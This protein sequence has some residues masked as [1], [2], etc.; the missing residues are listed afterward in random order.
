[1]DKNLGQ[2]LFY[3][4]KRL[5]GILREAEKVLVAFSGGVDST[6]LLFKAIEVLGPEK[7]LAVTAFSA[8]IPKEELD[9]AK[10][11]ANHFKAPHM[12][13]E[14]DELRRQE[15]VSNTLQRCYYCKKELYGKLIDLRQENNLSEVMDGSNSE[16]END[17]RPGMIA[18]HELGV[19]S[20]LQEAKLFK[21]EIRQLS[22][23][24][25]LPTWN[26][27]SAAC[28]ASRF[29]YGEKLEAHK[30]ERVELAEKSLRE[31]GFVQDMRVR[32]H[33]DLARI[34]IAE[35]E[36]ELLIEKRREIL[37]QLKEAG[38]TYTTLDLGG[39]VSGS[40]NRLVL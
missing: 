34:E 3:K 8:L 13:L 21:G 7:V 5:E 17:Y 15:I 27:P 33:G 40:M 1:M 4:E 19:R 30:L 32:S 18:T 37:N 20:P 12:I 38:F 25:E 11:L 14:T 24:H 31:L 22:Y 39:F 9:N 28:L 10:Q 26:K 2:E 16:D 23:K 36:M 35:E 29:P 6:F